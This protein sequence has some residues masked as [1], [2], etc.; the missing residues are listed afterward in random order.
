MEFNNT[1]TCLRRGYECKCPQCQLWIDLW[2][3]ELEAFACVD[4]MMRTGKS[5]FQIYELLGSR[6]PD[7]LVH[8]HSSV[9]T[10]CIDF[11]IKAVA[12]VASDDDDD[13][14]PRLRHP[15][16]DSDGEQTQDSDIIFSM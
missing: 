12:V 14:R 6:H 7:F 13:E 4:A 10:V 1:G 15:L 9:E 16:E 5:L 3:R 8:N 2:N 11:K